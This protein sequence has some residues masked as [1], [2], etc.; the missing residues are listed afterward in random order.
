MREIIT[1]RIGARANELFRT[2]R[3]ASAETLDWTSDYEIVVHDADV[4]KSFS[5]LSG[6]EKMAAA[7]AVGLP[8]LN[9]WRR[10]AS[11]SWT[12]R[13]QTSTGRRN[14]TWSRN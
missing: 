10:S 4:K 3:G 8:S 7:L 12:N 13:R 14:E 5:T 2:I 1:D 11:R 6:G 9:S